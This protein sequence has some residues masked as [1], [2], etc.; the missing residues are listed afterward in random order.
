MG[1]GSPGAP[2]F[3]APHGSPP[4]LPFVPPTPAAAKAAAA[5][6][7]QLPGGASTPG[8]LPAERARLPAVA[9][10][11]PMPPVPMPLP[12]PMASPAAASPLAGGPASMSPPRPL[13][14]F[15]RSKSAAEGSE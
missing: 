14:V 6:P 15:G 7:K 10:V 3:A 1:P 13:M 12:V 2:L 4:P 8:G 11:S 9:P 5:L